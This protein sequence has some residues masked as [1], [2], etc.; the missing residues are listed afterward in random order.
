MRQKDDAM[1]P[2]WVFLTLG[3]AFGAG[4][5]FIVGYFFGRRVA[6]KQAGRGFPVGPDNHGDH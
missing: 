1:F 2:I 3:I 6:M 5:G 4:V